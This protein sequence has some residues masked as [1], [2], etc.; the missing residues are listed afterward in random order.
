V[1]DGVVTRYTV[2]A[3]YTLTGDFVYT[4]GARVPGTTTGTFVGTN[5]TDFDVVF[6]EYALDGLRAADPVEQPSESLRITRLR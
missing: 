3:P 4:D 2:V 1:A 5:N 6:T